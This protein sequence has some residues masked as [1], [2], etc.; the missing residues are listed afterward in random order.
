MVARM[1]M[2]DA[3]YVLNFYAYLLHLQYLLTISYPITTS[4]YTLNRQCSS[5]LQAVA[6]IAAAIH[7]GDISVGI[8][9]G[10]ESMTMGYGPGATPSSISEKYI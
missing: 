7:R 3:G 5:G 1:A 2:L 6:S 4:V 9:A 8:G 10:V